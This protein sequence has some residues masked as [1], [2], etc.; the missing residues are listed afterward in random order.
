MTLDARRTIALKFSMLAT[1]FF[2]SRAPAD[3]PTGLT[4]PDLVAYRASL[5]GKPSGPATAVT[6]RRLWESAGEFEGKR[7]RIEGRV[8]RR[9]RQGAFGTF[10]PLVESWVVTPAGDPFC[11]VYPVP[12]AGSVEKKIAIDPGPG[13]MVRFEG[14][15]LKRLKYQGSDTERLGLLIVGNQPPTITTPAPLP[16]STSMGGYSGVDLAMA[17]GAAML[18]VMAIARQ[19][20][21]SPSRARIERGRDLDPPPLF[22]DSE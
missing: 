15:Y 10:P 19:Q 13:A 2:A 20:L 12:V 17:L 9:F 3:E 14:V 4:L 7:V 8:A 21:R 1:M 18:V 22:V 16:L 11:L 5:D 6:F